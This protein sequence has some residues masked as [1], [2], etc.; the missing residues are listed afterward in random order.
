MAIMLIFMIAFFLFMGKI[1]GEIE[2][3]AFTGNST[4][5]D[6]KICLFSIDVVK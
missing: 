6:I 4:H 2:G 1:D 5:G 3:V